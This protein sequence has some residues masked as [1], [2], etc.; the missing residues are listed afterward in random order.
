VH[1]G[2][3]NANEVGSAKYV[4][5]HVLYCTVLYCTSLIARP[6]AGCTVLD[7]TRTPF[8]YFPL[9]L[10]PPALPSGHSFKPYIGP[11]TALMFQ[12]PVITQRIAIDLDVYRTV[13]YFKC[14]KGLPGPLERAK[15]QKF[16]LMYLARSTRFRMFTAPFKKTQSPSRHSLTAASPLS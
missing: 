15:W 10:L 6:P 2:P 9:F 1:R 3:P 11:R 7:W 16:A 4:T 13:L 5:S 14:D 12:D 8:N